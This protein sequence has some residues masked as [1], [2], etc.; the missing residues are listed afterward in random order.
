MNLKS[1]LYI[2]LSFIITIY[3]I[4]IIK[5]FIHIKNTLNNKNIPHIICRTNGTTSNPYDLTCKS[6]YLCTPNFNHLL[7]YCPDNFMYSVEQ[8]YCVLY[9]KELCDL[10][11]ANDLN[12]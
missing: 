9:D 11:L 1:Y 8:N 3:V 5:Y 7:Q 10:Q 4:I 12:R 2:T 6:Y